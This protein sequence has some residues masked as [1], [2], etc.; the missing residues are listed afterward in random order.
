MP[1][2]L[3]PEQVSILTITGNQTEY[4]EK[5]AKE[6]KKLNRRTKVDARNEKIGY[7]IREATISRIP[8]IIVL[9]KREMEMGLVAV[10]TR[11]GQ[12]LSAMTLDEFVALLQKDL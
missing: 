9:G 5:V 6:L 3:A 1:L 10:R 11:E 2:W 12:D 4:A 7:K 8:Y